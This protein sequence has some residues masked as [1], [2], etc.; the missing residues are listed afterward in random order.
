MT[1]PGFPLI[2]Q[3][4]RFF[5]GICAETIVSGV[6]YWCLVFVLALAIATALWLILMLLIWVPSDFF[7]NYAGFDLF[8]TILSNLKPFIYRSPTSPGI[9]AIPLLDYISLYSAFVF[10]PWFA[11]WS[12]TIKYQK[13]KTFTESSPESS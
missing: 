11:I 10:G 9:T 6:A 1:Q 5:T 3:R 13:R 8:S 12:I 7:R 4:L 2:A